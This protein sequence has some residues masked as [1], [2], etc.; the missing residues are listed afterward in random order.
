MSILEIVKK[1][2]K[3][4]KLRYSI[5]NIYSAKDSNDRVVFVDRKYNKEFAIKRSSL[6]ETE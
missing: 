1:E 3:Q 5:G 6:I 2:E 4:A